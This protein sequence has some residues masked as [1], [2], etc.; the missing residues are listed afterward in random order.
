ME[1]KIDPWQDLILPLSSASLSAKR[2]DAD[3]RWNF[4]WAYAH[5][6]K[7]I[8]ALRHSAEV[9]FDIQF[10]MLK[11]IECLLTPEEQDGS[12]LLSLKLQDSSLHDIFYR[13][14]LDIIA[15]ADS[16]M[17]E[18]EVVARTVARTWRWH[19]LLR[20]GS[21]KRLSPEEQKGLI[22]ELLVIEKL[23]LPSLSPKDAVSS[24]RGPLGA[25]KD[26]EIGTIAIEAKAR[27]GAAAPYVSISSEYQLDRSG[28][29]Q[30]FLHVAD[31]SA[32]VSGSTDAFTVT[33]IA[34]RIEQMLRSGDESAADAFV[35]LLE[36]AGLRWEDDY[37]DKTWLHGSDRSYEVASNFPAIAAKNCATGVSLVHY[38][39]ALV[40]CEPFRVEE[41]FIKFCLS[42]GASGD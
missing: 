11:G 36:A 39:I 19:H 23:L 2:V 5:D 40:E 7:R 38:A 1:T 10:P 28:T 29:D 41:E 26:F 32:A 21:D 18:A 31:I 12:R 33:M 22:G 15:A 16:A 17:T 34:T 13:L 8:L 30:L 4:F 27:R 24:W 37:S 14:C 25:P 35:S 42:G 20:G 6:K 9:S 3:G